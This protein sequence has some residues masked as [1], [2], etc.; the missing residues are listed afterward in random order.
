MATEGIPAV[1]NRVGSMFTLFFTEKSEVCNFD[2]VMSCDT[3]KFAEYFNLCLNN[4]V[5]MA[6]SQ[7]EAAFV[8]AAHTDED[9]HFTIEK[10][11]EAL[12]MIKDRN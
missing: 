4:G 9:I 7:F 5:Y 3:K 11:L 2:D 8:S 6:P 10:N 12:K 1:I